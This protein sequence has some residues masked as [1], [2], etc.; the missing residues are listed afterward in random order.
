M[1]KE[2]EGAPFVTKTYQLVTDPQTNHLV[3]WS[4]TQ[5]SFV[6]WKPVDFASDILPQYFKHNNFCSFIRQLNTYGFHKVDGK[7]WEFKH[8]LFR[9]DSPQRLKEIAR[10]KAKKRN[11]G[12]KDDDETPQAPSPNVNPV[13]TQPAQQPNYVAPQFVP[14]KVE[15]ESPPSKMDRKSTDDSDPAEVEKLR[16]LNNLL[17]LEV[18][19]LQQ[20]QESTQDVVNAIL[21]QLMDSKLEQHK[22]HKKVAQLSREV[23]SQLPANNISLITPPQ[24]PLRLDIND[25][26][27]FLQPPFFTAEQVLTGSKAPVDP[28]SL[29]AYLDETSLLG[30]D[31]LAHL[32]LTPN[33]EQE[34]AKMLQQSFTPPQSPAHQTQY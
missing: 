21:E 18:H 4:D 28:N 26:K 8:D 11:N 23:Y 19:R 6:V 15:I 29:G 12:E 1:S 17:M 9:K 33:V 24:S 34:F 25:S 20:Q 3:S 2:L 16:E 32:E 22:L 7:Q 30:L 10:R 13:Q 5:D 14:V 31:N 27:K